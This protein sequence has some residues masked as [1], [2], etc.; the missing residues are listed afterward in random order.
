M[1]RNI[2]WELYGRRNRAR[3]DSTKLSIGCQGVRR[4]NDQSN[5][6]SRWTCWSAINI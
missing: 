6:H 5:G 2:G 3:S 1:I 4:G